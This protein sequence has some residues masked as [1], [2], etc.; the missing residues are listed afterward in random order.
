[1]RTA[2]LSVLI[3]F[4]TGLWAQRH[5]GSADYLVMRSADPTF[6]RQIKS[7]EHTIS[8]HLQTITTRN[9]NEPDVIRIPV[10]VHILYKNDW[11]NVSDEQ[12]YSQIEALNRDFRKK[13]A[14][15]IQ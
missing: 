13:N 14:D 4:A 5:C 15:T 6:S 12:V 7:A 11:E 1:M 2:L 9:T 10:V 8:Q 3:L